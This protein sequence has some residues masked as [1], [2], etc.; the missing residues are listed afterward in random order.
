MA[1]NI[2]DMFDGMAYTAFC[3]KTQT[4]PF[5]IECTASFK[6]REPNTSCLESRFRQS[7]VMPGTVAK[8]KNKITGSEQM[9]AGV[10]L[11]GQLKVSECSLIQRPYFGYFC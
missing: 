7:D 8:L 6:D 5:R 11:P 3:L 1:F 2:E 9:L 4:F 10:R